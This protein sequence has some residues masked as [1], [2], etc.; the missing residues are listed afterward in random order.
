VAEETSVD[1]VTF[2]DVR[3]FVSF[4]Y[5]NWAFV[6]YVLFGFAASVGQLFTTYWIS[7]WAD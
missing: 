5:G 2:K 6:L 4:S 1:E 7:M 3:N